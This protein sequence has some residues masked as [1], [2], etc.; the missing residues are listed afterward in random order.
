MTDDEIRDILIELIRRAR[1]EEVLEAPDV[2][3]ALRDHWWDD[4]VQQ[5]ADGRENAERRRRGA[6]AL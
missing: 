3:E 2:L 4:I 6:Y 1:P 5:W